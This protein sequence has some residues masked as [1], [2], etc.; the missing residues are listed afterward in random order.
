MDLTLSEAREAL[1]KY[2]NKPP[3]KED[4]FYSAIDCVYDKDYIEGHAITRSGELVPHKKEIPKGQYNF[5]VF[6]SLPE[7]VTLAEARKD[8]K[9]TGEK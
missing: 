9:N 5:Y 2:L 3:Y 1:E 6:I 4:G 8:E 7:G